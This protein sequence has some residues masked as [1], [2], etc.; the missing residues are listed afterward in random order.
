M[1]AKN[2]YTHPALK[3]LAVAIAFALTANSHA[4]R[5]ADEASFS[6]ITV[7]GVQIKQAGELDT[8]R[9]NSGDTA[10][11]L[12]DAPGVSAYTNGGASSLPVIHGMNDDRIKVLVDGMSITSAC[13]N[14]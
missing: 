2:S 11:L 7:T 5:A 9:I 8:R 13:A 6:E 3:P 12:D 4:V 10:S 14:H 1:Q